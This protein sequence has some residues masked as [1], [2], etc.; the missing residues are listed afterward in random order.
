ML[1]AR[2]VC[3][4]LPRGGR[5]LKNIYEN[6]RML[7]SS[8]NER[9]ANADKKENVD[10]IN[11]NMVRGRIRTKED[12]VTRLKLKAKQKND[13]GLADVAAQRWIVPAVPTTGHVTLDD[14]TAETFKV[15][16]KPLFFGKSLSPA[17]E[18]QYDMLERLMASIKEVNI[19]I[20]GENGEMVLT[21]VSKNGG[22]PLAGGQMH[23]SYDAFGLKNITASGEFESVP[24]ENDVCVFRN[25]TV[26]DVKMVNIFQSAPS[27]A[28]LSSPKDFAE[29]NY[30]FIRKSY[31]KYKVVSD[32]QQLFSNNVD[33]ISRRIEK[34]YYR[35][36]DKK[37]VTNFPD[38][39]IPVN[40]YIIRSIQSRKA[41]KRFL[42]KTIH[43]YIHPLVN[44]TQSKFKKVKQGETFAK[45]ISLR[46]DLVVR[47]LAKLLP[48]VKM[49]DHIDC[50]VHE[51]PVPG[52]NRIIRLKPQRNTFP[53]IRYPSML[54]KIPRYDNEL[55]RRTKIKHKIHLASYR[56]ENVLENS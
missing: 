3:S 55:G 37:L 8:M 2:Y 7:Y 13:S 35:L 15:A 43:N 19:V 40:S 11:N 30:K 33:W 39:L 34:E 38:H 41:L 27:V 49:D 9:N 44:L 5:L 42:R 16:H 20:Q 12:I 4:R 52:F 26:D 46:V 56:L 21:K 45:R 24:E 36:T 50:V 17:P 32:S 14:I 1:S 47:S 28:G 54:N 18:R 51:S 29:Q 22:N 31:S 53:Y 6:P 23:S 25:P 48:T 10:R